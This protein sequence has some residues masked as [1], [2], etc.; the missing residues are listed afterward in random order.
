MISLETRPGGRWLAM[1]HGAFDLADEFGRGPLPP[2]TSD[3]ART[4]RLSRR[5][6]LAPLKE[7]ARIHASVWQLY[8]QLPECRA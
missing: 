8:M 4:S 5:S 2:A 1:D 3:G 6:S 7:I